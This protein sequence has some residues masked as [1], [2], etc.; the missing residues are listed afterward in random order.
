MASASGFGLHPPS[1]LVDGDLVEFEVLNI[2]RT[3]A[4]RRLCLEIT[5][6]QGAADRDARG[7]QRKK[8]PAFHWI[9]QNL[10]L[11]PHWSCRASSAPVRTNSE[12]LVIDVV[13]P[14]FVTWLSVL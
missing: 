2:R 11:A 7:Q 12:L 14:V 1:E 8:G 5:N 4:G 13:P 6:R 3:G 10:N 9:P